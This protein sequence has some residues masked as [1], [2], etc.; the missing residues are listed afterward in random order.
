MVKAARNPLKVAGDGLGAPEVEGSA[1]DLEKLAGG[2]RLR[3]DR[4]VPV[5]ESWIWCSSTEP[6]AWPA[7]LKYVWL[8]RLTGVGSSAFACS[9]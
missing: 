9:G 6:E 4:Y 8:V 3:V 2:D 1:G 5:R 7:R